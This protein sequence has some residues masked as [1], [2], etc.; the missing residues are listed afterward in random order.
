[1]DTAE[2]D[3]SA[4]W[5]WVMQGNNWYVER[6]HYCPSCHEH[7]P[8]KCCAEGAAQMCTA[9]TQERKG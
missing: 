8:C 4:L 1:M 9:A 7:C 5:H 2:I 6:R 3:W